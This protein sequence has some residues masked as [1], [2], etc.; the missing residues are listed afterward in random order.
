M[1]V[2]KEVK[3]VQTEG[4]SNLYLTWAFQYVNI[5]IKT[6]AVW[7]EESDHHDW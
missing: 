3:A 4:W 7:N 6:L 2:S 5:S 1:K